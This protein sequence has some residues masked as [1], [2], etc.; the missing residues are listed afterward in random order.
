MQVREEEASAY[1]A[2]K[3]LLPLRRQQALKRR[4]V[5]YLL[6]L[7]FLL[8][9]L[10]SLPYTFTPAGSSSS[11]SSS[12][13]S[14]L[15]MM[16]LCPFLLCVSVLCLVVGYVAG[17]GWRKGGRTMS[18]EE[19]R[20]KIEKKAAFRGQLPQMPRRLVASWCRR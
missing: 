13:S 10:L 17:E 4:L 5:C 14:R 19:M 6:S 15:M 20:E 18:E 11:S 12:S 3:A 8:L 1:I 16:V 7:P 9:A 2:H